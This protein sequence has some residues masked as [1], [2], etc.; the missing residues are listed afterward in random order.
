MLWL[1]STFDYFF[2]RDK[3]CAVYRLDPSFLNEVDFP[4]KP[5][6]VFFC[7]G[8]AFI[9]FHVRF[10]DIARGGIRIVKSRNISE[11]HNNLDTAFM[12]NYN[13]ALIN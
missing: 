13:L 1:K 3:I 10:R 11:Y 4:E 2:R 9:G 5:F 7:V 6:S 12:E 8:R